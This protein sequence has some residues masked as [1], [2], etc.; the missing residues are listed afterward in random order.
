MLPNEYLATHAA[1]YAAL[2]KTI[3]STAPMAGPTAAYPSW[4][5]SFGAFAAKRRAARIE[6]AAKLLGR[7]TCG[8]HKNETQISWI[9]R[10]ET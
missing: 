2:E 3:P 10:E 4:K 1:G 5:L 6:D 7:R 8:V 9:R